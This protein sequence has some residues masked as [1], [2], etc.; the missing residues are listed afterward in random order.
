MRHDGGAW[1]RNGP[2]RGVGALDR[3]PALEEF[4]MACD[5]SAVERDPGVEHVLIEGGEALSLGLDAVAKQR[6]FIE[7]E[8]FLL[9]EHEH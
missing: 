4:G 9:L 1:R 8:V 7:L 3:R 2:R 6:K 5:Q